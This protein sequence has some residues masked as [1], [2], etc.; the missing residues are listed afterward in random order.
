VRQPNLG[1]RFHSVVGPLVSSEED[2]VLSASQTIMHAR[3][4]RD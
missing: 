1:T 2:G 3:E 4:D